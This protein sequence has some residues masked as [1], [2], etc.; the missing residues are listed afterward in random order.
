M[1]LLYN[2][3]DSII[4]ALLKNSSMLEAKQVIE[5]IKQR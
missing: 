4:E 5:R 1:K 2:Q 3:N